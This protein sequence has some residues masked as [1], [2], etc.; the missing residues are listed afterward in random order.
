MQ[1]T[2]ENIRRVNNLKPQKMAELIGISAKTYR[3]YEKHPELIP[4]NV[5]I[6]IAKIGRVSVD[7]I[8]FG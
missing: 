6:E 2:V 5:A 3:L 4:P 8:F 7:Y 1:I